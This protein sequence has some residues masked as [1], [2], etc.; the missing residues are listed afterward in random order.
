MGWHYGFKLHQIINDRG[1]LLAFKLTTCGQALWGNVD[2]RKPL[3]EMLE[4]IFG[5]V[6]GDRGYIPQDLFEELYEQ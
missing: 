3:P 2:D 4:C 5:K 6:F 1:E